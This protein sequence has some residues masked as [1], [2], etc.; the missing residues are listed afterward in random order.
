MNYYD[1]YGKELSDDIKN[2]Y[3][4]LIKILNNEEN[5]ILLFRGDKIK[6]ISKK[7]KIDI[8]DI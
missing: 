3:L 8:D 7:L 5:I 2:K 1:V 6:N 4:E